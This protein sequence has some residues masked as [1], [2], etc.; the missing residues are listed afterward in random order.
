[1]K[2]FVLIRPIHPLGRARL[3]SGRVQVQPQ[4]HTNIKSLDLSLTQLDFRPIFPNKSPAQQQTH[5]AEPDVILPN[6]C[7]PSALQWLFDQAKE[8]HGT[9]RKGERG[10]YD[11]AMNNGIILKL[12]RDDLVVQLHKK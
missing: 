3:K 12:H 2:N 9:R 4:H 5:K 11:G 1:M 7:E 8:G 10:I 6:I